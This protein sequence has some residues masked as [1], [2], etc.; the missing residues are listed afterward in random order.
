MKILSRVVMLA[1]T[2]LGMALAQSSDLAGN[3]KITWLSGGKPNTVTMT[4]NQGDVSGNYV[5]DDGTGCPTSGTNLKGKVSLHVECAK[6][7]IWMNGRL[8]DGSVSGDYTAY[9]NATGKFKMD[10]F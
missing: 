9:G 8:A 10:R 1:A 4:D 6:W 5:S 2:L 3:W 7:D